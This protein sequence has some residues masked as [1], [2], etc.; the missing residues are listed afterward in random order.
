MR[1]SAYLLR[2]YAPAAGDLLGFTETRGNT[3]LNLPSPYLPC[4]ME[5][6]TGRLHARVADAHRLWAVS[7]ELRRRWG[8]TLLDSPLP[9]SPVLD[10]AGNGTSAYLLRRSA[11]ASGAC[12]RLRLLATNASR[13]LYARTLS[14]SS[15][16]T[17]LKKARHRNGV[18]LLLFFGA[19]NGTRTREC[20]LGKLM[21]Y[22]LAMPACVLAS[23]TRLSCSIQGCRCLF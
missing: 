13:L 8:K 5:R 6:A 10:G 3:L 16:G 22:H 23:I 17:L 11:P 18:V 12:R 19:G 21:P 20:Q 14:G 1:A 7:S 15:P 4:S 9:R 2:K